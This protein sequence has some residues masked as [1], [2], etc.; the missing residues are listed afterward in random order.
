VSSTR[1]ITSTVGVAGAAFALH[2]GWTFPWSR[3]LDLLAECNWELLIAAGL[4]NILSLTAKASAW[5]MLLARATPLRMWTAQTATFVGA[6]VN[7]VSISIG[8]DVVRAQLAS[9]RDAVP[10]GMSAA[11]LVMSRAVEAVALFALVALAWI[12]FPL[13][14]IW[15]IA[16]AALLSVMAAFVFWWSRAR[17]KGRDSL[18]NGWH[19]ELME[20]VGR[21]RGRTASAVGCAMLSWLGQWLTYYWSFRATHVDISPAAALA[22]LL[23][24]NLAGVL[25]LTP[26]NIGIMQGSLILGMR[27]FGVRPGD[28]LAGGLALQ[29]IQVLPILALA[30]ALMGRRG[31]RRIGQR[32]SAAL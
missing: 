17:R 31:F 30:T 7:S 10:F 14:P 5:Y 16:G 3:I 6:A 22:A 27:A 23:A 1:W 9:E 13:E 28:A 8:G 18:T 25:R 24:A 11:G 4:V 15:R 20:L 12:V 21:L 26:G 19:G 29:A 32:R 2:F